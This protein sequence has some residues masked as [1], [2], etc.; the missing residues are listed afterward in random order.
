[1]LLYT[2]GLESVWNAHHQEPLPRGVEH[3]IHSPLCENIPQ[4]IWREASRGVSG[5]GGTLHNDDTAIL[6]VCREEA[7]Q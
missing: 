1:M 6:L 7:K 2:D 4:E 3:I 5:G